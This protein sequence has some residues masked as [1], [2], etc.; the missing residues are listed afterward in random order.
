M[1]DG[2]NNNTVFTNNGIIFRDISSLAKGQ[3]GNQPPPHVTHVNMNKKT[4]FNVHQIKSTSSSRVKSVYDNLEDDDCKTRNTDPSFLVSS[5]AYR[6]ADNNNKYQ[7][8][9]LVQCI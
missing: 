2:S 9:I 6:G 7:I 8:I 5:E 3:G 4:D 1:E